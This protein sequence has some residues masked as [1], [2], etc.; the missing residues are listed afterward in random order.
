MTSDQQ[1]IQL[2]RANDEYTDATALAIRLDTNPIL[3]KFAVL[4]TGKEYHL[5]RDEKGGVTVSELKIGDAICNLKG[6]HALINTLGFVLN[7]QVVQGY[8]HADKS[9]FS[10][11]YEAYIEEI[12]KNLSANI[13]ENLHNW[14]IE[15]NHYNLIVDN[16]MHCLQP[17]LTRLLNN[18]ERDS[19]G[20]SLQSKDHTIIRPDQGPI[21]KLLKGGD[22][23][24]DY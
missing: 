6:A 3:K 18:T 14:K 5:D 4:L 8:F 9:G 12:H 17:F 21:K 2:L 16:I 11:K 13:M 23:N 7:P 1:K 20:K 24:W 19:F 22:I 15:I 10:R